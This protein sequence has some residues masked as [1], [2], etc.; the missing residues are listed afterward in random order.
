MA[1]PDDF[2][3]QGITEK[4]VDDFIRNNPFGE[5]L[6]VDFT[7]IKLIIVAEIRI[8]L[9]IVHV[10]AVIVSLVIV[11]ILIVFDFSDDFRNII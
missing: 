6:R 11:D 3:M 9:E 4:M 2:D 7:V 1:S 10:T 8:A 5:F